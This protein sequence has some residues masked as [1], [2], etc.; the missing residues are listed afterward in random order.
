MARKRETPNGRI[1]CEIRTPGGGTA[2]E[3][4]IHTARRTVGQGGWSRTK[5]SVV[6]LIRELASSHSEAG[7]INGWNRRLI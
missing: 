6:L 5:I 7:A 2:S 4:L 3:H 1:L